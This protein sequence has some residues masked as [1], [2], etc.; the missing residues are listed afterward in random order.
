MARHTVVSYPR[1]WIPPQDWVEADGIA[2]TDWAIEGYWQPSSSEA[3]DFTP[4]EELARDT[5][6]VAFAVSRTKRDEVAAHL[7]T[8]YSKLKDDTITNNQLREM[9]RLERTGK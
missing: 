9:L 2:R 1:Q 4:A 6:E 5:E 3:V 8:L 7:A